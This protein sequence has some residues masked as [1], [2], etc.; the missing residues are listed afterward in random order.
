MMDPILDAFRAELERVTLRPPAIRCLSNVTGTWLTPGDAIDPGYW[1]RHLRQTVRFG[2]GL[3]TLRDGTSRVLVE[4]G[5]GRA[6]SRLAQRAFENSAAPPIV[7]SMP[8]G[9]PAIRR[10]NTD[11]CAGSI[12]DDWRHR[13]LGS[14]TCS[15][16]TAPHG[17]ADVS[18]RAAPPLDRTRNRRRRGT[19]AG[20]FASTVRC[21]QPPAAFGG[22]PPHEGDNALTQAKWLS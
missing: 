5:P 6:L 9:R 21:E 14:G 12:V 3:A 2:D 18:V 15:G 22:C 17:A 8:E 13:R 4:V 16:P 20:S 11:V 19:R 7:T 1:V 10:H